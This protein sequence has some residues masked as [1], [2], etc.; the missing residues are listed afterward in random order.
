MRVIILKNDKYLNSILFFNF[1][2]SKSVRKVLFALNPVN[3]ILNM[4]TYERKRSIVWHNF[5][6]KKSVV[7][8][9]NSVKISVLFDK[10]V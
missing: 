9:S 2:K 4:F 1:S 7:F 10:N 3:K 8:A 5:S 6:G